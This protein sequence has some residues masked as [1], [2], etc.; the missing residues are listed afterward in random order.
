MGACLWCCAQ[1]EP[2]VGGKPQ[3]F[4]SPGCR[5]AFHTAARRWA[6]DAVARGALTVEELRGDTSGPNG[7]VYVAS[8][9]SPVP[10]RG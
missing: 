2:R 6:E 9:R 8:A 1:F 5:G 7:N 4:C 3:R 10:A